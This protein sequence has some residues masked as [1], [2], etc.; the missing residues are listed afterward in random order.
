MQSE[1]ITSLS[2]MTFGGGSDSYQV[3]GKKISVT[4]KINAI[5]ILSI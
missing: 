2:E 4:G 1:T 5:V 3:L